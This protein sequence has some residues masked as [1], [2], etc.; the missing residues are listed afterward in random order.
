MKAALH[1][2]FGPVDVLHIEDVPEPG[3][4]AD[5]VVVRVRATGL[6]RL[7]ILQRQGPPLLPLFE[8]PHIPGMDVVGEVA[9]T[10]TDVNALQRGDR[11]VI[12][13]ALPCGWCATC[14]SGDAA[15]CPNARVVGGNRPGGYA[16]WVS[17]PA[18]HAYRIPDNVD[19]L[20]ACALPTA[21]STAWHALV[22][23]GRLESGERILIHGAGSSVSLAA[24]EIA[25][26]HGA[27][28]VMTST[29]DSKLEVARRLGADVLVNNQRDDVVAAVRAA[30]D[31]RGVDMVF[32]HVG[33]ALFQASLF[34]LRPRGRMVFCGTTTGMQAS[35]D[36]PYAYHFGIRLLGSDPYSQAEFER[37]LEYCFGAQ[38]HPVIDREFGLDEARG[39]QQRMEAGDVIGKI[40]LRP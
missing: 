6:N 32:D 2:E 28:V 33:P 30:T 21:Y 27:L 10:G 8:L 20:A 18:S 15:M 14:R 40:V 24:L 3:C 4:A 1:R 26:N 13:P 23:T 7:D 36:L 5:E 22:E 25:R 39:A 17:V 12:N 9:D 19:D 37:V 34:C 16:E 29:S 11:V 38:V 31:G 35:F